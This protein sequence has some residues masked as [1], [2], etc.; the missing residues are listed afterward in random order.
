MLAST[1][2][3]ASSWKVMHF[4]RNET[5]CLKR[6]FIAQNLNTV[7]C[8]I[9]IRGNALP[10]SGTAHLRPCLLLAYS[11]CLTFLP[12]KN[13]YIFLVFMSFSVILQLPLRTE[14][15]FVSSELT[16]DLICSC[17]IWEIQLYSIGLHVLSF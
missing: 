2:I 1:K 10:T 7:I 13:I 14:R 16:K 6:F 11:L 4:L 9:S 3:E 12:Q 17:Y 8:F 15:R 5:I